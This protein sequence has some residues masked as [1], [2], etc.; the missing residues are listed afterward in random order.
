MD[1]LVHSIN[2]ESAHVTSTS[3][4]RE[5]KKETTLNFCV[6]I[7]I[8]KTQKAITHEKEM[9]RFFSS[10]LSNNVIGPK[11]CSCFSTAK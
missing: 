2:Y 3:E 6:I 7:A 10:L 5:E 11:K 9:F 1:M 4:Q 8:K